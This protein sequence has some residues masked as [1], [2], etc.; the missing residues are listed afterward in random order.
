MA[1]KSELLRLLDDRGTALDER[2]T[3]LDERGTPAQ[4]GPMSTE[5]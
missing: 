2:A 4:T 3:A 1:Y 5:T